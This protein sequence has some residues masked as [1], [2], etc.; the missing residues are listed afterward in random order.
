MAG[1]LRKMKK[2]RDDLNNMWNLECR[3]LK[4]NRQE[5]L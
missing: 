5:V 4:G 3:D 1:R 2:R